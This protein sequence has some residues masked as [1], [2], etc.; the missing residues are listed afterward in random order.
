ME[1]FI[2]PQNI[3]GKKE[4]EKQLSRTALNY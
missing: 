2:S 1:I 4:K 3:G